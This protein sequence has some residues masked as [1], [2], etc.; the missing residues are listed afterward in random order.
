ME[1]V[2]DVADGQ[3]GF[4]TDGL[5]GQ[6]IVEL[7]LDEFTAAGIEA[8]QADADEADAF[9]ADDLFIRERGGVGGLVGGGA[10]VVAIGMEGNEP[11]G[12]ARWLSAILWTV[13]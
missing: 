7:E 5:V 13:R 1:Q 10:I 6:V 9:Q 8:F 12:A 11:G 4:L 3:T 2:A